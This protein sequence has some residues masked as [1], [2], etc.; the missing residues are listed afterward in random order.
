MLLSLDFVEGRRVRDRIDQ[1]SDN[2][3]IEGLL[4]NPSEYKANRQVRFPHD[5][6]GRIY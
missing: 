5:T 4:F 6:L 2:K 1:M 3:N